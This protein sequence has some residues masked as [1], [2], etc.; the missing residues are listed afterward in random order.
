[1]RT[2]RVAIPLAAGLVLCVAAPA[3]G[4]T[5]SAAMLAGAA[6]MVAGNALFGMLEGIVLIGFG[7][8]TRAMWMALIANYVS[9]TVGALL[10]LPAFE[11]FLGLLGN[12]YL[13]TVMP[14]TYLVFV[15]FTL[16]G[17]LIELPFFWFAFAKPRRVGR[18]LVAAALGNLITAILLAGWYEATTNMAMARAFEPAPVGSIMDQIEGET[19]WVYYIAP[20]DITVRRV[21]LDGTGDEHVLE[22]PASLNRM[23]LQVAVRTDGRVDLTI[24]TGNYSGEDEAYWYRQWEREMDQD[25][26]LDHW[27]L[28][29]WGGLVC[30]L[31]E[32][33]GEAG[34]LHQSYPFYGYPAVFDHV[35]RTKP[36]RDAIVRVSALAGLTVRSP[37]RDLFL[38]GPVGL[39]VGPRCVSVLPGDVL[40]FDLS[41]PSTRSSRGIYVASIGTMQHARLPV[42]GRSPCVVYEVAPPN[43][44]IDAL[45]RS[46]EN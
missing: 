14:A 16:L 23:N 40:V 27:E 18:V 10:A 45:L 42:E 12:D 35:S 1:M 19:P 25:S 41:T 26:E 33:V 37:E 39:G 22:A 2:R 17:F 24:V 9:A 32:D 11:F 13:A 4:N 20:D 34:T 6:H 15:A 30:M 36:E 29:S 46:R 7:A 44:D 21:R 31:L 8:R 28:Y 43:W 38:D 5:A 3:L